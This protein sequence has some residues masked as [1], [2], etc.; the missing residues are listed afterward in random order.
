MWA[1]VLAGLAAI[2]VYFYLRGIQV[3]PE[4]LAI[5]RRAREHLLVLAA[6]L[7]LKATG[8]RLA[9]FDLLFSQ[10][11]RGLRRRLCRRPCPA[12]RS[13]GPHGPGRPRRLLCLMT[14]RLRSWRP[15]LGGVA[16]LVGVAALLGESCT[17]R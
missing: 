1:L 6:L 2:T 16:A 4:R 3:S 7:L 13:E 17:P 10:P 12:P 11:G 5:T 8:Y 14:I 15:L 9:M